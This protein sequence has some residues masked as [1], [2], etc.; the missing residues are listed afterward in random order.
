MSSVESL[1]SLQVA[2]TSPSRNV[3]LSP[4]VN[5][6]FP[7]WEE[8]LSAHDVARLTRRPRWVLAGL[9]FFGHFPRKRR[10]HGHGI[11]WRRSEVLSWLTQEL[12]TGECRA[13]VTAIGRRRLAR[14]APLPLECVYPCA[15]RRR[16]GLCSLQRDHG[17]ARGE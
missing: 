10:Y 15:S 4:F 16:R 7:T 8:L 17:S 9:A 2:P 5:E 12:E 11:G 14:Q 1:P 6:R 13:E 3:V